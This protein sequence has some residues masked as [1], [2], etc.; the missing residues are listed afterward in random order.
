MISSYFQS[1][2]ET[3]METVKLSSKG[4]VVIPKEIRD[5]KHWP[6]GTSFSILSTSA[7]IMLMPVPLFEPT[8]HEQVAGCLYQPGRG[9]LSDEEADAAVRRIA[10]ERDTATKS[11]QSA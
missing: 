1:Y 8:T 10:K 6:P 3:I 5:A 7:G 2:R 11:Q 9:R 4:Q